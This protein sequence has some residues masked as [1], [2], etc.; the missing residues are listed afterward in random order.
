MSRRVMLKG[1]G[2]WEMLKGEGYRERARRRRLLDSD[3]CGL[4]WL[5]GCYWDP[6][7]V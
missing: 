2:C 1:E 5:P 3:E 7:R 6:K 4:M